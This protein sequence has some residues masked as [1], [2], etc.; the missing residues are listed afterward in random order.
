M[1]AINVSHGADNRSYNIHKDIICGV[2]SVFSAAFNGS[3]AERKETQGLKMN[4]RNATSRPSM[5]SYIRCTPEVCP[6]TP[7]S[8]ARVRRET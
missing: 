5:F 3:G 6:W 4:G 8:L 2:S 7:N 1:V